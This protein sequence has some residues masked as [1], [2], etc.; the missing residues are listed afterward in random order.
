MKKLF[1]LILA[2]VLALAG[3]PA[4]AEETVTLDV[5][6]MPNYASLWSVVTGMEIGAF[7]EEGL[8][9]NLVEF[10]DG[11]TIIAAMEN[12]SINLGYIGPGAHR[13]CIQGY[14][15]IFC[16]SHVG[17][18]DAVIGLKSKGVEKPEDLKGKTVGYASGTSS[19][20]ILRYTLEEAGLTWDDIVPYE[21]D[22]SALVT[23]TLSGSIDAC[24]AWS[25]S[26]TTIQNEL[27]DDAV[28]LANNLTFADRAA[29]I[30]SWIV[31]DD[32]YEQNSDIV[33]RFTRGLYKAMDYSV[34]NLEQS[35]EW[36][37]K[38]VAADYDT[39]YAQR[40]D[41]DWLHGADLVALA[42]DGTMESFYKVQQEGFLSSGAITEEVSVTDY[43]LFNNML[44]AAE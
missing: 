23:A 11:P 22:A 30:A 1:P 7:E 24:A 17:N 10:A 37:A 5:A 4:L 31:M 28:V 41:G 25:P 42:K 18:A 26:T 34:E 39:V 33:E 38:V 29:S 40:G 20:T 16:M 2:L 8:K 21:M 35:C 12:G 43:V 32:Y 13:L 9:I 14:A 6:Y 44:N 36:V 15:K 3:V 19:E 27:G